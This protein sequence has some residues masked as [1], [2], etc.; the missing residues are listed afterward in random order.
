MC[1]VHPELCKSHCDRDE[2]RARQCRQPGVQPEPLLQ[3]WRKAGFAYGSQQKAGQHRPLPHPYPVLNLCLSLVW[4]ESALETA[5]G[6][7]KAVGLRHA[8]VTMV[9]S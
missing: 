5:L 8:I 1:L 6:D 4:L 7:S 9:G 3:G 2:Q